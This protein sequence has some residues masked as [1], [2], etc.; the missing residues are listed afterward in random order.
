MPI[1]N[2]LLW[3]KEGGLHWPITYKSNEKQLLIVLYEWRPQEQIS[4][5]LLFTNIMVHNWM[6]ALNVSFKQWL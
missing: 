6:I 5:L 1:M 3:K 4:M 2:F